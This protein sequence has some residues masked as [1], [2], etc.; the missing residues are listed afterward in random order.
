MNRHE[1]DL[2]ST[3]ML[4]VAVL[5]LVRLRVGQRNGSIQVVRV[6]AWGR[7]DTP[8]P[9]VVQWC[10]YPQPPAPPHP[11]A[12]RTSQSHSPAA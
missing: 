7:P 10:K 5:T 12:L 9:R 11:P 2:M 3:P 6:G 8:Q 4:P 1:D